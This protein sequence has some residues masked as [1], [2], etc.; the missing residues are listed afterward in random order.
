MN[1][2]LAVFELHHLGDAVMALPF[3][4]GAAKRFTVEVLC[5]PPVA[6][7]LAG[8]LPAVRVHA[9]A[10]WWHAARIVRGMGLGAG[11]ATACVWA[12]ARAA[13]LARLSGAERR[14][15][16]PMTA[17]NYHASWHGWRRRRLIAGRVLEAAGGAA[18]GRPLLNV[19]LVRLDA[20]HTGAWGQLAE[21]LGFVP[22]A[23]LPWFVAP[24]A[25][26]EVAARVA[27][28]R[29]AGRRVLVVHPGGRLPTKRWPVECFGEL[30]RRFECDE[31]LEVVVI[32]APGEAVPPPGGA[33]QALVETP[34]W[35]EMAGV[36]GLAD[37]V[38]ANDSFGSHT[39]AALGRQVLTI[40]GS[41]NP[42]WFA[43]FGNAEGV[44]DAN[45]CPHRPCI[46][47]C[48][49]GSPVCLEALGVDRVEYRLREA[50]KG[51]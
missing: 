50:L 30:L 12:D 39:A 6:G 1:A 5:R 32:A 34:S 10:S 47:R 11:D 27:D 48:V 15:G 51:Q 3:L 21:A 13:C 19:P 20:P 38:L 49:M 24:E 44:I 7:M 23:S 46:D 45:A 26:R 14:A 22:D 43:P 4:R 2:R 37:L 33:R 16:F 25:P 42:V 41:G 17:G 40:F 36:L 28:A 31:S 18:L 9:S 29:A 35:R 8:M